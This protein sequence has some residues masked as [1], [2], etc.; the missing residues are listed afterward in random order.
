MSKHTQGPWAFQDG[1]T[2]VFKD[3]KGGPSTVIA[4]C[5]PYIPENQ[6]NAQLIAA[7]PEMLEALKILRARVHHVMGEQKNSSWQNPYI[8]IQEA[9]TKAEGKQNG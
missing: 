4:D 2:A 8:L 5:G 3:H 7:A 1:D 6:A 9:I